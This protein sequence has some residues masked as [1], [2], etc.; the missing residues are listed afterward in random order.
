ML[1]MGVSGGLVRP[2]VRARLTLLSGTLVIALGVV[3]LARGLL[4]PHAHHAH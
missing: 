2:A 4:G 1:G 3:T